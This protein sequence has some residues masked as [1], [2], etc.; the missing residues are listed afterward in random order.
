MK[1]PWFEWYNIRI[2]GFFSYFRENAFE[3]SDNDVRQLDWGGKNMSNYDF[4][5]LLEPL[6]FQD[7]VCDIVQLRDAIFLET[8]K[9]G[10]DSGIDGSYTDNTQKI[11]VQVS[12]KACKNI[13]L[14]EKPWLNMH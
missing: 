4:H 11:I 6:E 12:N 13:L 2:K 10:R 3:F 5:A 7:L 8:Y 1:I 9:E 14:S